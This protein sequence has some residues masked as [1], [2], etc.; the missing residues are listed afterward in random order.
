MYFPKYGICMVVLSNVVIGG[1]GMSFQLRDAFLREIEGGWNLPPQVRGD[2]PVE[3]T[4]GGD[5]VTLT[6][7]GDVYMAAFGGRMYLT[8]CFAPT[9]GHG[10]STPR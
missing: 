1:D 3:E 8:K 10:M 2:S 7:L 4:L 6:R 9:R 5:G